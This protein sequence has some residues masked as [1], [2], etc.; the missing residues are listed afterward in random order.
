MIGDGGWRVYYIQEVFVKS[1][2]GDSLFGILFR[3]LCSS[4]EVRGETIILACSLGS[5]GKF[6]LFRKLSIFDWSGS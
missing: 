6:R 3:A 4:S 5:V 2:S 1:S